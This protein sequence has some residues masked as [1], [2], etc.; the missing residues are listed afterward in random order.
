MKKIVKKIM[1]LCMA[2]SMVLSCVAC[3]GDPIAESEQAVN[4]IMT[5]FQNITEETVEKYL[6]GSELFGDA[7]TD[8]NLNDFLVEILKDMDYKIISSEQMDDDTVV[9]KT[10]ISTTDM[11]S[12]MQD[13]YAGIMDFASS[14]IEGGNVPGEDE[15]QNKVMDIFNEAVA[16]EGRE[17]ITTEVEI[18]VLKNGGS[19]EVD[20]N[21]TLLNGVFGGI[22]DA[23]E[24]FQN[25]ITG[26]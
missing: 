13:L 24:E 14:L 9:V 19:W 21:E 23:V 10:E 25:S 11:S 5:E 2:L 8:E 17:R 16:E 6:K 26:Q 7:E 20:V 4:D 12:V 1:V 22:M 15:I 18:M 3:G